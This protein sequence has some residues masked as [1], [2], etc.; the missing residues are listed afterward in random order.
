MK[1]FFDK[2]SQTF[3]DLATA[4][5]YLMNFRGSETRDEDFFPAS[6]SDHG[7]QLKDPQGH[8]DEPL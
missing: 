1:M 5:R 8:G 4:P 6:S 2:S 3:V 7:D